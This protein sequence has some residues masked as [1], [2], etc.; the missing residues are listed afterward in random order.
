MQYKKCLMGLLLCAAV[1]TVV[2]QD[3]SFNYQGRLL[4]SG[5]PAQ[6]LF[7]F[8]FSLFNM[9]NGGSPLAVDELV[10]G[11]SLDQGIFNVDLDFASAILNNQNLW[12]EIRVRPL[13][14]G[15]FTLLSP[16][17]QLVQSPRAARSEETAA[18]SV[19]SSS[20][21]NGSVNSS[22]IITGGV[23]SVNIL[24]GSVGSVDVN[25]SQIQRRVTGTCPNFFGIR[26]VNA[27]GS[28]NCEPDMGIFA[29]V[30]AGTFNAN[31][32]N[33]AVDITGMLSTARHICSLSS[34]QLRNVDGGSEDAFCRVRIQ[35]SIWVLEATSENDSDAFCRALCVRFDP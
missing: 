5:F 3:T 9:P 18:N 22:K 35:G 15:S 27:D 8:R 17:Q 34:V 14:N 23:R 16:R 10:N 33:G 26:Q 20:I 21:V 4:Q 31:A 25:T 32:E 30:E 6:G 13:G 24:D 28:V 1:S 11:L 12:L 19:N 2:A 29:F 7:D